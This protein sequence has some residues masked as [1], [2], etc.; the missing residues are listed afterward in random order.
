MNTG[1]IQLLWDSFLEYWRIGVLSFVMTYVPW[2]TPIKYAAISWMVLAAKIPRIIFLS[3]TIWAVLGTMSLVIL[4]RYASDRIWEKFAIKK[5]RR[6]EPWAVLKESYWRSTLKNRQD[7]LYQKLHIANDKTMS[8]VLTV[9]WTYSIIPDILVIR[10]TQKRIWVLLFFIA[11]L[12]WKSIT[13]FI[14][15]YGTD[16]LMRFFS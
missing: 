11:T 12:L 3:A 4:N 9:L 2:M 8:F 6:K 16:S 15:I 14:I 5:R 1:F 7:K 13:N 10:L